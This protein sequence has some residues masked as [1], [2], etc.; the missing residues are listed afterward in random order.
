MENLN[1]RGSLGFLVL[2][3]VKIHKILQLHV[4]FYNE[5]IILVVYFDLRTHLVSSSKLN[6]K[7]FENKAEMKHNYV[8]CDTAGCF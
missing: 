6:L 2:E 7:S 4:H 1:I 8:F 3:K 5:N